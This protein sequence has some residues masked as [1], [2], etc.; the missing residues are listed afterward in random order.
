[1]TLPSRTIRVWRRA[2]PGPGSPAKRVAVVARRRKAMDSLR[3][4]RA[5][6]VGDRLMGVAGG[7]AVGD[8]DD[9]AGVGVLEHDDGALIG[10]EGLDLLQ[11]GFDLFV[12]GAQ[13]VEALMPLV[14]DRRFIRQDRDAE[15]QCERR[16]ETKGVKASGPP[17]GHVPAVAR[18]AQDVRGELWRRVRARK[19]PH[20]VADFGLVH[21]VLPSTSLKAAGA[22]ARP[23]AGCATLRFP[24]GT[25]APWR[26]RRTTIP[27]SRRAPA[28]PGTSAA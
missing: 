6:S 24:A 15:H 26:C 14:D 17:A 19:A 18:L 23:P 28:L 4:M 12:L 3:I 7:L 2:S 10:R 9:H 21:R 1:M 25:P 8:G 13:R 27:P 11:L 5:P 22:S 20:R 16:G